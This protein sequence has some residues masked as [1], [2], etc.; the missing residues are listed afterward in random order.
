MD[1]IYISPSNQIANTFIIGNFNE[2]SY[3]IELS[4]KLKH[5]LS[6]RKYNVHTSR[7]KQNIFSRP[8][9]AKEADC[10]LYIALHS[11]FSYNHQ[12][13]GTICYYHPN[14]KVGIQLAN[15]ILNNLTNIC[16]IEPNIKNAL[17][18]GT[19][20]YGD[21][22]LIEIEYPYNLG[23]VAV[24]VEINFHDNLETCRWL[25]NSINEIA[26]SISKAILFDFT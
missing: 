7:E 15:Q 20:I 17:R 12:S 22:N 26:E 18:D 14:D 5:Y 6:L 19:K 16:P 4:M 25:I 13:T 9:S 24:L 11:S 23:M 2:H 8:S 21:C 10:S 1:N 3:A